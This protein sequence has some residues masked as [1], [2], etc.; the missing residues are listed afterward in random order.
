LYSATEDNHESLS[1]AKRRIWPLRI[2]STRADQHTTTSVQR[3]L[4]V[5]LQRVLYNFRDFTSSE[6]SHYKPEYYRKISHLKPD[7]YLNYL[8]NMVTPSRAEVGS[9]KKR[10]IG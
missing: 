9:I 6:I 3:V 1:H 8:Y 2:T 7:F 10:P 5:T 4:F